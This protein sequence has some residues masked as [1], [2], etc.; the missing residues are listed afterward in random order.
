MK[1]LTYNQV[2]T[3]SSYFWDYQT[4]LYPHADYVLLQKLEGNLDINL[5]EELIDPYF[6]DYYVSVDNRYFPVMDLFRII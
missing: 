5:R 2:R 1:I 6:W 3:I 4:Q